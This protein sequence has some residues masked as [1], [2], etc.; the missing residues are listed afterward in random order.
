M[1]NNLL[2]ERTRWV[3]WIPVGLGAG[4]T[5]YFS[6]FNEPTWREFSFFASPAL[7][8][9]CFFLYSPNG[10]RRFCAWTLFW[11]VIGFF[12]IFLRTTIVNP[13]ILEQATKPIRLIGTVESIDHPASSARLFQRI[14]LRLERNRKLPR[15]VIITIRTQCAPLQEGDRLRLIA[16]LSP[17]PG[18]CFP[19]GHNPRRQAFFQGIG[20][21]GFAITSPKILSSSPRI[22]SVWRHYLTRRIHELVPPPLGAV[23]CGLVT[24]DKIAL[25]N[26]IREYFSDSG[27]SHLLAIAGLHVSIVSG[28]CFMVSQRSLARIPH[29]ALYVNLD[30]IAAFLSLIIGWIYLNISGQ[31]YPA[32][33]A[34][35]MMAATMTAMLLSRKR[36]SMRILMLCAAVFLLFEPEALINMSYQLSF[37]AVAGL[38]AFYEARV[39]AF[40]LKPPPKRTKFTPA[41]RFLKDS[42]YSTGTITVMTLPIMMFHF[43][44][45]SLQGFFS[46]LVAIPFTACVIMPFGIISLLFITTPLAPFFFWLWSYSLAGLV[47]IAK[48]SSIYFPFLMFHVP[49]FSEKWLIIE[50]IGAFWILLWKRPWRWLGIIPWGIASLLGY[51]NRI[52]PTF[53][54]DAN[55]K[56]IGYMDYKNAKLWVS[57]SRKGRVVTQRW[58]QAFNAKTIGILAPNTMITLGNGKHV[59]VM[60]DKTPSEPV[61]FIISWHPLT[62]PSFDISALSPGQSYGIVGAGKYIIKDNENRPWNRHMPKTDVFA[63]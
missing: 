62:I 30:K 7:L 15:K 18:P 39:R 6:L 41:M 54:I 13:P 33:R 44:H 23:A 55:H 46:N 1:R 63:P 56:M 42:L 48:I 36:N 32:Q 27:L 50:M 35:F 12:L 3:L 22:L 61:D 34:F 2:E 57:S 29:L 14:V 31:R 58:Q 24:G 43:H 4:I 25:A 8:L 60:P 5:L 28:L 37:A 59:L 17:L 16:I 47:W 10:I 20:A 53:I 9:S 21:S 51:I 40:S 11:S 45:V 26:N 19:G 38:I 52:T 49:P